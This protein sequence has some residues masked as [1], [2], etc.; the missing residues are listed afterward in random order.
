M[1]RLGLTVL[2]GTLMIALTSCSWEPSKWVW[3]EDVQLS[4]GSII[5]V[6]QMRRYRTAGEW[7]AP[8]D[9]VKQASIQVIGG[10]PESPEFNGPEPLLIDRSADGS[11]FIVT[12]V[13]NELMIPAGRTDRARPPYPPHHPYLQYQL[14]SDG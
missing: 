6:R 8:S 13:S 3:T 1:S 10:E 14:T 5:Q 12:I 4:D 7:A 9:M 11:L 2:L